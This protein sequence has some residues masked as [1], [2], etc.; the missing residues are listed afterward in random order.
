MRPSILRSGAVAAIAAAS[1]TACAIEYTAAP[2][3]AVVVDAETGRPLPDVHIV[4]DWQLEG[5]LEGGNRLGAI[6]VMETQTDAD[7]RFAFPGWGPRNPS[8]VTTAG[9]AR[10]KSSAPQLF[11]FKSGYEYGRLRNAPSDSVPP[12][13]RSDWDGKSIELKPF[14]GDAVLYERRLSGLSDALMHDTANTAACRHAGPCPSACQWER[15]PK[16][17]Q[18]LWTQYQQ[19]E[20]AGIRRSNIIDH[21][22]S[23]DAAY[24]TLGCASPAAVLRGE[25]R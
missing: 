6:M 20:A 14:R 13:I 7:G 3:S 15:F 17:L 9:N 11:L 8:S 18:A 24:R 1:L 5:G 23:N 10:L 4:A 12:Q 2:L 21:L 19:F 25:A 22:I 16:T